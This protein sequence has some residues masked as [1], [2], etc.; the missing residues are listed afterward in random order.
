[1]LLSPFFNGYKQYL[2]LERN[3]SKNTIEAYLSDISK[4]EEYSVENNIEI[5]SLELSSEF[6][7][8]FVKW[9]AQSGTSGRSQARIL[10]GIRSFY[11]YLLLEKKIEK[12]PTELIEFPKLAKNLPTV[13]S[14]VEIESMLA[15]IDLSK[16]GGFR[17][18]VILELL[19]AC[20][21]R[22]SELINLEIG[23]ISFKEEWILVTGKGNKQR[24]VP[25]SQ[26]ALNLIKVYLD[27]ERIHFE[28]KTKDKEILFLNRRGGRLTRVFIF[29]VIK[30]L[31]AKAGI[32]KKV[33]PHTFRHSFATELV[34]N[35]A[36]LRAVQSMLGHQ[37][38]T[39]T[40]IYA[41]LDRKHLKNVIDTFH[42]RSKTNLRKKT[43]PQ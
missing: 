28:A 32:R 40:E 30:E 29:T 4:V 6:L 16:E 14:E 34:S 37:S 7:Q 26:N 27:S 22:V 42:P 43:N 25:V 23:H 21:L 2:Q 13:L 5:S 11:D 18:K 3:L 20:G 9:I 1:M 15:L 17:N 35:G 10:S 33:S 38:I 8:E 39:T 36:D 19:F 31:A 41:H 24:L 12:N